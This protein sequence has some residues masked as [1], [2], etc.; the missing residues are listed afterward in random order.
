M[1]KVFLSMLK[2]LV[3]DSKHQFYRTFIL[4]KSIV[5]DT[6]QFRDAQYLGKQGVFA[7]LQDAVSVN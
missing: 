1:K 3:M 2:E 5:S 6:V 4:M 7:N